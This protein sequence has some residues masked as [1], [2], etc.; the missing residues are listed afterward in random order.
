M[1]ASLFFVLW[2]FLTEGLQVQL[3]SVIWNIF[4]VL[5]NVYQIIRLLRKKMPPKFTELE[6]YTYDMTF[7]NVFNH[8]EYKMLL[9]K[10]R[11]EYLSTNESQI[12]KVGQSFKDI[13]YVAKINEGFNIELRDLNNEFITCVNEGSWIGIGEYAIRE[14]YLK[15]E[16]IAN[17]IKD[18]KY[19]LVWEVTA[20]IVK[21]NNK[22]D[23]NALEKNKE[24]E[25]LNNITDRN[26]HTFLKK[27]S[28]G[29]IIYRYSME[30]SGNIN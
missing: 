25:L 7:K 8:Y 11:V 6:Q 26:K 28:E 24:N 17:G 12:C 10:A 23:A 3:E 18:G 30:V 2:A 9:K 22:L 21:K 15:N 14:E 20:D 4:F 16:K 29:C 1:L 13:I 19:E 27:R 5:I